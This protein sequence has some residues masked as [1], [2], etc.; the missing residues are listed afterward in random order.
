M[1]DNINQ[2]DRLLFGHFLLYSSQL[3]KIKVAWFFISIYKPIPYSYIWGNVKDRVWFWMKLS[4]NSRV[5]F[6][7]SAGFYG[8]K[9]MPKIVTIHSLLF[10]WRNFLVTVWTVT[11]NLL[12]RG[13]TV[14]SS[15]KVY[16]LWNNANKL[17]KNGKRDERPSCS[18]AG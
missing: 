5:F 4:L 15:Y 14:S 12:C 1:K 2:S 13:L 9:V 8:C 6:D 7:S 10:Y 17:N 16:F 3:E 11:K 18:K